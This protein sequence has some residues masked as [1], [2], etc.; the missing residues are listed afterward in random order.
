MSRALKKGP[1]PSFQSWLWQRYLR[2]TYVAELEGVDCIDNSHNWN[3]CTGITYN[4]IYSEFG[5]IRFSIIV[6]VCNEKLFQMETGGRG[7]NSAEKDWRSK[8][9]GGGGGTFLGDT[10]V[11]QHNRVPTPPPPPSTTL[12]KTSRNHLNDEITRLLPTGICERYSQTI[13][14]L[15]HAALL[16]RCA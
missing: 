8:A 7:E 14:N 9:G 1:S 10:Q 4:T 3:I 12:A 16:R 2:S 15:G 11:G 6:F 13:S 5:F